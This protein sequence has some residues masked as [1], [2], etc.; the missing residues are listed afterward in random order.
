MNILDSH[1]K[2]AFDFDDTLVY[3]DCAKFLH[4]YILDHPE[5]KYY[6]ITH[7]SPSEARSIP[8][9]LEKNSPL[10]KDHF[11]RIIVC[12]ERIKLEFSI[13]Q[14][15]RRSSGL[16]PIDNQTDIDTMFPGEQKFVNWKGFVAKKLGVSVLVD[17]LPHL[18]KQGAERNGVKFI[19][20]RK[21]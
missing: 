6:I 2:I 15:M 13:D 14:Q 5:K 21:C 1:N 16:P 19:D 20:A 8:N 18:S 3:S 10:T 17:D 9:E 11:E 12:P 7:R 4:N